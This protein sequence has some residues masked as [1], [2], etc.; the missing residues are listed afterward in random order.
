MLGTILKSDISVNTTI[1]VIEAF[2]TM[3]K[4]IS[5]NLLEQRYINNLVLEHDSD[6]KLLKDTFY[7]FDTKSNEIFYEGQF[8]DAY[9]FLLDIFDNAKE[10]IIVIDNFAD[11]ELFKLLS[12]TN[13]KVKVFSKNINKDLINKYKKQYNNVALIENN[14][15]HNRFIIIDNKILY[16]C[17]S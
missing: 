17:G 13:K 7:N 1:L 11:K 10:S 2:V 5:S 9:A 4:Y 16:S 8:F 12:K 3:K 6:I 15:Y 14:S